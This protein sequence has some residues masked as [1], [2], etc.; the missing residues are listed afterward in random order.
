MRR[1][2]PRAAV[3]AQRGLLGAIGAASRPAAVGQRWSTAAAHAEEAQRRKPLH[4]LDSV[5]ASASADYLDQMY[6]DWVDDPSSVTPEMAELFA[7][8]DSKDRGNQLL[9]ENLRPI[10]E[11]ASRRPASD[12]TPR[13][14]RH[15][16]RVGWMIRQ[17]AVRGHSVAKLDPLMLED[18]YLRRPAASLVHKDEPLHPTNFGF[19]EEDMDQVFHLG[20]SDKIGGILRRDTPPMTL[21]QL[22]DRLQT[23]YAGPIGWEYMH[24]HKANELQWLRDQIETPGAV[25]VQPLTTEEKK[26]TLRWLA[27]SE[28]FERF[29][30]T[31]FVGAK[32]FGLDG[33]EVLIPGLKMLMERASSLG[34]NAVVLGMPHRGRLN[35]LVN[36]AGKKVNTLFQE[37]QGHVFLDEQDKG[38]G[39]GDVKYHLG[40]T[41]EIRLANGRKVQMSMAANPSHL[42]AVNPIVQGKTRAKH[43]FRAHQG[44]EDPVG[45]VLSILLHGDAAFAGQ[46]VCFESMGLNDLKQYSVGGTVHVVVNNQI[47]FTTDPVSS[48][49]TPYCTDLGRIFGAPI[50]HVNA[51]STE[52]VVRAFTFAAEWRQRFRK[53]VIIDLVC[54]RRFG[55]NETDEP[56]FTQPLMYKKISQHTTQLTQYSDKLTAEGVVTA[57]ELKQLRKEVNDRYKTEFQ[58]SSDPQPEGAKLDG[59]WLESKWSGFKS[60]GQ[61]A[62][63]HDSWYPREQLVELGCKL[64]DTRNWPEGFELHPT[65]KRI[66][67]QRLETIQKGE[68]IDWGTAEQLA[69]G[70]LVSEGNWVR[71]SGQD[72]ERATFSQRHAVVTEQN[73]GAKFSPL[74]EHAKQCGAQCV[75]CNSSLSEYG[76]LGFELGISSENP[77]QLVMW[78][79]QFGDF[80]NTAQIIFDQFLS[81]GEAKW[82]R[83]NGLVV[84]LPHGYDG[85]GPEHSSGRIERFLQMSPEPED[86][87]GWDEAEAIQQCNWVVAYPSTPAQ[88]FHLLRRQIHREFRKPLIIFFSKA[89]LRAPNVSSLD[90]FTEGTRFKRVLADPQ[91]DSLQ[92]VRKVVLCTGQI[93]HHLAAA[94]E[95]RG[96]N[97]VALIRMEQLAPFPW[98][99]VREALEP[100]PGVPVQWCQEEPRNMGAWP[101]VALRLEDILSG[102]GS[103]LSFNGRPAA[104]A[105]ATGL[106]GR[107]DAEHA[108]LMDVAF[109]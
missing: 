25:G 8:A 71:V 77:N 79:A 36:V 92:N 22:Y 67:D 85:A 99:R 76:V 84:N 54:Y 68:G 1:V 82:F 30:Q 101:F 40:I 41:E 86:D 72:V 37:F 34:V 28:L 81:S 94:R 75:V 45:E 3:A 18:G 33:C 51:D 15:A 23:I 5:L 96:V 11:F 105:P 83:Q 2:N 43:E 35:T 10:S 14:M 66:F 78:E 80:S 24:I 61:K 64:N 16:T 106:K 73:T 74:A 52:D 108:A 46:G 103:R 107:H 48:R 93:Y 32:R 13:T 20:V 47:G 31:K 50:V 91:R 17:W 19:A 53:D 59:R 29:L 4:G 56:M 57:A 38:F 88:Y 65:V 9:T 102:T 42:E 69:F 6:E 26:L 100:Y 58:A 12:G 7:Q 98:L 60:P 21:R 109:Q 104:A 49:S 62:R 89:F 63:I 27:E 95:K 70:S 39:S 44:V 87:P 55:H 90:Q 97:D